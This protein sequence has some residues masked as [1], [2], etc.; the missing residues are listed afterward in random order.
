MCPERRISTVQHPTDWGLG[1]DSEEGSPQSSRV[2]DDYWHT[3]SG[4]I[5]LSLLLNFNFLVLS[6]IIDTF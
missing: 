6:R 2:E 4:M 5:S 1:E 3:A